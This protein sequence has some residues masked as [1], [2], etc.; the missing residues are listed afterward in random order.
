M[1]YPGTHTTMETKQSSVQNKGYPA[2]SP[3]IW[4]V[5]ERRV[6]IFTGMLRIQEISSH[7]WLLCP[8]QVSLQQEPSL[9]VD[10]LV[11][12]SDGGAIDFWEQTLA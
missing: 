6:K 11:Y 8:T 4:E 10:A 2:I 5:Q 3:W 9:T 7:F 12:I 1:W